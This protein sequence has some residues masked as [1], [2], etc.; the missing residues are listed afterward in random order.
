[1]EELGEGVGG[2]EGDR[3]FT[4]KVIVSTNQDRGSSQR[5][6]HQPKS[7][8]S[9]NQGPWHTWSRCA[10]PC[11]MWVSQLERQLSLKLLPDCLVRSP[12]GLRCLVS[13]GEDVSNAAKT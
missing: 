9:L 1:M 4:G 8:H 2:S 12:T 13:V 6:S 3:N 7:K 10:A 5:L 11:L